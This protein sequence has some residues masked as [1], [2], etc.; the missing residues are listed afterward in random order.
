MNQEATF[1]AL[2][3]SHG[4]A[5]RRIARA[6]A[7]SEGE[8]DDLHQEVLAQVWRALP[9]YRGDA[10]A[11]TW[12]YRVA[13]NTALGWRRKSRKHTAGHLA[14]GDAASAAQ[15]S[16]ADATRSE[17]GILADFLAGLSTP[18]R[19][20]LLLYMEGLTHRDI[21]DVTGLSASAVGV[22]I[23]RM[24]RTFSQRYVEQ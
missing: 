7:G 18:D 3:E 21:A 9:G 14:L 6:Y 20:V 22:R 4:D 23:H 1:L 12:M 10:A 8:E 16:S 19:S 2:L 5:L 24:K 11:G 15:P 13:L 17:A